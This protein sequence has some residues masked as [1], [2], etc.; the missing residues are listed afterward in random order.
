MSA[1]WS[2]H[3]GAAAGCRC[4]VLLESERCGRFGVACWEDVEHKKM[5]ILI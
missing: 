1:F 5:N 4:R 2:R 3:A